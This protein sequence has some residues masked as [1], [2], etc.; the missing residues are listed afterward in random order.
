MLGLAFELFFCKRKQLK[1]STLRKKRLISATITLPCAGA[2][3]NGVRARTLD[4]S[5][6]QLAAI[7]TRDTS[8]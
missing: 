7:K 8:S 1:A 6:A 5:R 2:P 4:C 3:Q